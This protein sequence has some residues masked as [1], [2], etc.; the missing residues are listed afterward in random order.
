[1]PTIFYES[2]PSDDFNKWYDDLMKEIGDTLDDYSNT[3]YVDDSFNL[4]TILN[5]KERDDYELNWG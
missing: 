5:L 2:D 4:N 1:V 3:D